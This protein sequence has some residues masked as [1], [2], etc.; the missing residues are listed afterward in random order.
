MTPV[1]SEGTILYH[2]LKA[3]YREPAK[4]RR[5]LFQIGAAAELFAYVEETEQAHLRLIA[6]LE[7]QGWL[8][9][10][11]HELQEAFPAAG[12][13]PRKIRSL[14]CPPRV[15][16]QLLLPVSCSLNGF[17]T[18]K[19]VLA[20]ILD[21]REEQVV[22]VAAAGNPLRLLL[23]LPRQYPEIPNLLQNCLAH[24]DYLLSAVPFQLLSPL[25]QMA[26]QYTAWHKPFRLDEDVLT[27]TITW[28]EALLTAV[29]QT[30]PP[31]FNM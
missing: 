18:Q 9:C 21:V 7:E 10:L 30:P 23:T 17:T 8:G 6:F 3:Q 28:Q 1:T 25:A 24:K 13:M 14:A 29:T 5:L 4:L 16:L 27:P 11:V 26:W 22:I 31:V 2:A 20:T 12:G 19:R 15:K